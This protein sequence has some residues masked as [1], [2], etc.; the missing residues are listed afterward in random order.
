MGRP[1]PH[2]P[3]R[4]LLPGLDEVVRR[5][6]APTQHPGGWVGVLGAWKKTPRV[7]WGNMRVMATGTTFRNA[8]YMFR[9]A[10]YMQIRTYTSVAFVAEWK[11][12]GGRQHDAL[13][14]SPLKALF[15]ALFLCC[16]PCAWSIV[17]PKRPPLPAPTTTP[18]P[19]V[20]QPRRMP[21]CGNVSAITATQ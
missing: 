11:I 4:P 19:R 2:I 10:L 13:V 6:A 20:T 18:D 15:F 12:I 7:K 16:R 17:G 8:L 3:S 1:V 5:L 9:N 21:R 14:R